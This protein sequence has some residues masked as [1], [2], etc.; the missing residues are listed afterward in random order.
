VN[1][2]VRVKLLRFIFLFDR[3]FLSLIIFSKIDSV[4]FFHVVIHVEV[5]GKKKKKEKNIRCTLKF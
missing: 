4:F 1:V 3:F 2:S 5:I